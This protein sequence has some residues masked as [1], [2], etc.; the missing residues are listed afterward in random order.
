VDEPTPHERAGAA[1]RRARD[2][3]ARALVLRDRVL[4]TITG[5]HATLARARTVLEATRNIRQAITLRRTLDR[6]R[7]RR[8]G[9][10]DTSAQR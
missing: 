10:D 1:Y 5:A 9:P 4:T 2:L 8:R 6:R 3:A 7:A